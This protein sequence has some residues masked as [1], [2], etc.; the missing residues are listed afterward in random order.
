M[1]TLDV[2]HAA[3]QAGAT[4]TVS[5]S[6]CVRLRLPLFD[7]EADYA[8]SLCC[9]P[10][11]VRYRLDV[12]R[13][14]LA[15][16]HWQRFDHATRLRLIT[17]RFDDPGAQ[18]RYRHLLMHAIVHQAQA[19][20]VRMPALQTDGDWGGVLLPERVRRNALDKGIT[21]NGPRSWADLD[22]L[23]RFALFKLTRPGHENRNFRLALDEFGLHIPPG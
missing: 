4:P 2:D 3:R 8:T 11:V 18:R 15:L 7:F 1:H 5:Q 23:Q 16:Q 14:K 17:E 20:P 6:P 13:I 19:Q 12:C 9:M 21:L 22:A 10:M